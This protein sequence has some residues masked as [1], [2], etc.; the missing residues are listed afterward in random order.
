MIRPFA[1][2]D[3]RRARA[4]KRRGLRGFTLIELLIAATLL[5]VLALLSWRGLDIFSLA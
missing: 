4:G 1:D 2:C 5:A 3:A